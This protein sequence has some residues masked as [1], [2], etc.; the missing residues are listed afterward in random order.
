MKIVSVKGQTDKQ[1]QLLCRCH[2]GMICIIFVKP[3]PLT[4][5]QRYSLARI[6]IPPTE[7]HNT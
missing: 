3:A 4:F 2:V 7:G 6:K 5:L 1:R